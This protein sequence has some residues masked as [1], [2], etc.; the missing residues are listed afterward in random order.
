MYIEIL[1]FVQEQ[2]TDLCYST[3]C[4]IGIFAANRFWFAMLRLFSI[5]SEFSAISDSAHS[6][7]R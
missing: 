7:K 1:I 4:G 3:V 6:Q 2:N 5:V